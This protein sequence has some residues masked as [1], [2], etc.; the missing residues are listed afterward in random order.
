M[1][2][3]REKL[4]GCTYAVK[5]M[6]GDDEQ[7]RVAKRTYNILRLF[8]DDS[9]IRGHKLFIDERRDVISVVMEYCRFPSLK[10]LLR[11]RRLSY[12]QSKAVTGPPLRSSSTFWRRL[13]R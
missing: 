12:E 4:T 8:D 13:P 6:T 5:V 11:E 10:S 3:C 9:I 7:I 2:V 1:Y